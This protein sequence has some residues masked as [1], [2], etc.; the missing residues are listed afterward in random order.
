MVVRFQILSCGSFSEKRLQVTE[1]QLQLQLFILFEKWLLLRVELDTRNRQEGL[2]G[3]EWLSVVLLLT[4]AKGNRP[5]L[6][7]LQFYENT[8]LLFVGQ[9]EN[10]CSRIRLVQVHAVWFE[11]VQMVKRWICVY[12]KRQKPGAQANCQCWTVD[13]PWGRWE[14]DKPRLLCSAWSNDW[15][16]SKLAQL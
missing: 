13:S 12:F 11:K 4:T 7:T 9:S 6:L 2:R 14:T 15:P 3:G 5:N 16:Q 8:L 10:K 1:L